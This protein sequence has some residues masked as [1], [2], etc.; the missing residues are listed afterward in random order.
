M[1]SSICKRDREEKGEREGGRKG[2]R[3][4][5]ERDV[6]KRNDMFVFRMSVV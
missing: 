2:E 6:E 1:G 5:R 4:E 3:K